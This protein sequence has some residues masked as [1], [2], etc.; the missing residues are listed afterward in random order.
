M[1]KQ[2]ITNARLL[3]EGEILE[4]DV[5]IAGERIEKIAGSIEA[6]DTMQVHDANGAILM[7]GMIDDQVHFRE[8]GLTWKGDLASESAAA[9]AGG[10]GEVQPVAGDYNADGAVDVMIYDSVFGQGWMLISDGTGG[11]VDKGALSKANTRGSKR[12]CHP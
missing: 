6:D 4:R 11:F 12:N 2:L 9:A 10:A 3:N 5:L 7:P 1:H 8:P